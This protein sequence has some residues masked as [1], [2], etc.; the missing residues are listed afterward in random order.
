MI[1]IA[2][3]VL[4]PWDDCARGGVEAFDSGFNVAIGR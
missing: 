3:A 4:P 1:L 2:H